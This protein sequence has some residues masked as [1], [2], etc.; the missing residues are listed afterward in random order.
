L[1]FLPQSGFV[2]QGFCSGAQ[3]ATL[4]KVEVI[5]DKIEKFLKRLQEVDN[6]ETIFNH[7]KDV[8][9]V[10]NLRV[11]LELLLQENIDV[12]MLIGEA[13]G[14]KGCR[15][16]GIPFTSSEQLKNTTHPLLSKIKDRLK[17]SNLESEN[18]ANTMWGFLNEKESVPLLWN[19]FPFHPHEKRDHKTNRAPNVAEIKF[20]LSFLVELYELFNPN[21]V[22]SIGRRGEKALKLAFPEKTVR[23]IR[24]LSYG[25]TK[26]FLD[27][28]RKLHLT[29]N[30][31]GQNT[32]GYL[33]S[34][35]F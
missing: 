34:L 32:G 14:Y 19:S 2:Q 30:Q 4:N 25:G 9:V 12:K 6:T 7:Y 31:Q 13:H 33:A 24:H 28:M 35:V 27:G 16:T 1:F 3:K 29:S 8:N 26:D 11:Y 15:I 10:N 21:K 20:G 22:A 5:M 23:Y 17:F 18:T